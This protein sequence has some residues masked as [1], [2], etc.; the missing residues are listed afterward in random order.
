MGW[1]RLASTCL[2]A[3]I[4]GVVLL[5]PKTASAL[6][7]EIAAR[8]GTSFSAGKVYDGLEDGGDSLKMT[9]FVRYQFPFRLDL[10]LRIVPEWSIGPY[11]EF[12]P[13]ALGG[14]AKDA[15]GAFDAKCG[16]FGFRLGLQTHVHFRP[17]ELVD[18]WIGAG[19]GLESV[20]SGFK[21][22]STEITTAYAGAEYPF[23]GG[24]DFRL[25]KKHLYLGPYLGFTVGSYGKVAERV[26]ESGDCPERDPESIQNR[27]TH[28][29]TTF[30]AKLTVLVF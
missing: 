2:T 3:G 1:R 23:Q 26:C 25:I 10:G 28:Y 17:R 4:A 5:Q 8:S 14:D 21:A 24:I 18:P 15:C 27:A 29:W 12:D 11:L 9:D 13:S 30:G 7:L 20:A 19:I 6:Q 16:A 22:G